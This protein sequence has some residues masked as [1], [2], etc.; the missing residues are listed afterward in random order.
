MHFPRWA[1]TLMSTNT[2]C[3]YKSKR[4]TDSSSTGLT[5]SKTTRQKGDHCS[6]NEL[7]HGVFP[8]N[9]SES[10][11]RSPVFNASACSK[12]LEL[13]ALASPCLPVCGAPVNTCIEAVDQYLWLPAAPAGC[14]CYDG[15]IS[16][17]V[18]KAARA[19]RLPKPPS[20]RRF[21]CAEL[22]R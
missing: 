18:L 8:I 4:S 14:C 22:I 12:G 16:V 5:L 9:T 2:R 21:I 13:L 1:K 6:T 7:P 19:C 17:P 10:V 3:S 20:S 11:P 15:L